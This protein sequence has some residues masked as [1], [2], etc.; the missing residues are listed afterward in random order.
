MAKSPISPKLL[1]AGLFRIHRDTGEVLS[2]VPFQYNPET[3]NRTLT[4]RGASGEGERADAL[5]LVGP[6]TETISLEMILDATEALETAEI[7]DT[8][9]KEG[10]APRLA[11]LEAMIYP[12]VASVQRTADLAA[13][14]LIEVLPEPEPLTV[15]AWSR[16]RIAAVRITEFSVVEDL[17]DTQLNPIRV[18]ISLGLRV[19]SV[20]DLGAAS[21]GGSIFMSYFRRKEELAGLAEAGSLSSFG[22]SAGDLQ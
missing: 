10:L 6:P 4:P 12:S 18:T 19:L 7:G 17:H 22:I 5:R 20:D 3:L 1:K 16:N 14:G 21:R 2:V 9:A 15:M 13:Q 11:T 8:M